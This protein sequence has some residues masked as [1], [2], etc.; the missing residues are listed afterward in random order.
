MIS[1]VEQLFLRDL[2]KLKDELKAYS[3]ESNLWKTKGNVENSAGNLCLHIIGNLKW[4]IGKQ[5]GNSDYIRKR[6]E[7]FL[8]IDIPITDLIQFIEETKQVI[9]NTLSNLTE[10][11]LDHT[12]PVQVFDHPMTTKHFLLHLYSHLSYHLGQINYH[13]RFL[14]Q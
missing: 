12:Y 2:D 5:L 6:E 13:R 3:N 8:E 4:F 7:E 9:Q 14:D 10:K 11:Q 1:D